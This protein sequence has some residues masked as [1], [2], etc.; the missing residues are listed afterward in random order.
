MCRG[1]G[2]RGN[3]SLWPREGGK[4]RGGVEVSLGWSW[5]WRGDR[6]CTAL[7]CTLSVSYQRARSC[8]MGLIVVWRKMEEVLLGCGVGV[9][10]S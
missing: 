4:G 1:R 6:D 8:R 2:K 10:V 3:D 5:R 9:W 7:T